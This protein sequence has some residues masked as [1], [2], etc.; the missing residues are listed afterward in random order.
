MHKESFLKQKK[1]VA[2]WMRRLYKRGLTTSLGGNIS[3][4]LD[5]NHIAI[6]ASGTDKGR[7]KSSGIAI[8]SMDGEQIDGH[9][10]ISMETGMHLAIYTARNDVNAIVHAHAPMGSL[11]AVVSR[12]VNTSLLAEAYT[13]LGQPKLAVYAAPGSEELAMNVAKVA[14]NTNVVLMANHG[15]LAVGNGLLEAFDRIEVLENAA[16]MTFLTSLINEKRE[17]TTEHLVE[18]KRLFG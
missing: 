18:L 13:I 11:F 12:G 17:L 2:K 9:Q 8:V 16:K 15:V 3:M 4:R 1:D 6:T 5:D 10:P 14:M 7:I